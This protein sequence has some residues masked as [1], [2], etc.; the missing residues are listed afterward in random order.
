MCKRVF[1]DKGIVHME[2]FQNNILT[3]RWEERYNK[4]PKDI[5]KKL[6]EFQNMDIAEHQLQIIKRQR[7]YPEIGDIFEIR[8]N[9]IITLHGIV[10]NNH[11]NNIN[12]DDLLLIVIFKNGVD[13]RRS[14]DRGIH[15]DDLL[16]P[17][18]I[19]GK[20]Y[21]SRGYFYNVSKYSEKIT[22]DNYGFYHVGS[23]KFTDEYGNEIKNEPSLIGTG[24]VCTI[25]GIGYKI[26]EEL[27][28][29]GIV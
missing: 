9:E 10:V 3:R 6:D 27:I 5:Q 12:G 16:I 11:I 29:L 4:L 19:V 26:K 1:G 28:A 21:W 20:E 15:R 14:T 8:P 23:W 22:V 7:I 13:V 24:G 2:N 17:P 25:W 18:Q